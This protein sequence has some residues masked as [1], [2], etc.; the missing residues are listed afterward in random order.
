MNNLNYPF[1]ISS[2]ALAIQYGITE[3]DK[4]IN[5]NTFVS[6]ADSL[7]LIE[8][9]N[10]KNPHKPPNTTKYQCNFFIKYFSK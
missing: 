3:K 2:I 6:S 1:L 9:D 8:I 10:S 4:P 7:P 5:K